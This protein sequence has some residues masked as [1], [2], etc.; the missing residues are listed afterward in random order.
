MSSGVT[1]LIHITAT[2][3]PWPI[4]TQVSAHNKSWKICIGYTNFFIKNQL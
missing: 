2:G 1:L 3:R 4:Y